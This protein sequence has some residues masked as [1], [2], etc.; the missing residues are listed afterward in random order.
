[1]AQQPRLLISRKAEN[2]LN[3][4][5]KHILTMT[6]RGLITLPSSLRKQL[7]LKGNDQFQA[8][9][10]SE[11][12]LLRPVATVPIEVYS[13]DRINEFAAEEQ[14]LAKAMKK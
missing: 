13:A 1:M 5:M 6:E 9:I 7:G 14:K 10:T 12:I 8:D 4:V 11:G 2:L 3:S